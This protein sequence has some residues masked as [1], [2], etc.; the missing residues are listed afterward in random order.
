M[1]DREGGA[2]FG[3]GLLVGAA[4]GLAIGFLFAPRPGAETRELLREKADVARGRAVEAAR[5]VRE[6]AGEAVKRA[7]AK[8]EES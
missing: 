2:G 3:I 1:T 4:I 5:K 7:R 6:T 8:M